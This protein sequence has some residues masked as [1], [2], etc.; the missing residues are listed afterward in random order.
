[1]DDETVHTSRHFIFLFKKINDIEEKC[2]NF[3]KKTDA[4]D[5]V[6]KDISD[7][8]HEFEIEDGFTYTARAEC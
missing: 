5:E 2:E 4:T 1:L 7:L 3:E 8:Q 6:R